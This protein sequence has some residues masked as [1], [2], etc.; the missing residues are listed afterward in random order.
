M[1]YLLGD[2]NAK[3]GREDIFKTTIGN[4]S[5]YEIG[6]DN[7][8]RVVNLQYHKI[9]QDNNAQMNNQMDHILI[10]ERQH[11]SEDDI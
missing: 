6:S 10:G 1:C 4:E 3:A 7:V 9:C 2:F 8:V 11:S 5:L